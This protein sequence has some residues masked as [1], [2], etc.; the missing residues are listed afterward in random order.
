MNLF[1]K[2]D[3]MKVCFVVAGTHEYKKNISIN[4]MEGLEWVMNYYS[5]GC[6]DWSWHYKYN[7]PPLFKDLV[8]I[9][10]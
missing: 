3:I 1:G 7:Y 8:K 5:V 4:F 9:C 6:I 10:S 2:I